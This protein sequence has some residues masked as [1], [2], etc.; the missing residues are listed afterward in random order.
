[1]TYGKDYGRGIWKTGLVIIIAFLLCIPLTARAQSSEV[2]SRLTLSMGAKRFMNQLLLSNSNRVFYPE[3]EWTRPL[4]D[5][6]RDPVLLGGLVFS[7][8]NDGITQNMDCADCLIYNFSGI[9]LG[10]RFHFT[11]ENDTDHDYSMSF[12]VDFSARFFKQRLV[13]NRSHETNPRENKTSLN[14]S[15]GAGTRHQYRILPG[16]HA[17]INLQF[18][19]F[20]T[21]P[22]YTGAGFNIFNTAFVVSLDY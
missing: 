2:T 17:G 7:A 12:W 3:I 1:M 9:S 22:D 19:G 18:F 14:F 6:E 10:P 21:G 15:S 11:N 5:N 8:W 4:S 16:L 13:A 20:S